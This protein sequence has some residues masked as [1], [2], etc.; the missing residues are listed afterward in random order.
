MT[1]EQDSIIKLS[2]DVS[3]LSVMQSHTYTVL[4]HYKVLIIIP[5]NI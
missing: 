3:L 1:E 4:C 2:A 5:Q